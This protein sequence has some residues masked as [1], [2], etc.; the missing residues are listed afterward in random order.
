MGRFAKFS[1]TNLNYAANLSN[2][3]A[4][5]IFLYTVYSRG[6]TIIRLAYIST[7]DM[8]IFTVS[9]IGTDYQSMQIPVPI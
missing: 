6:V 5:K 2:L 3:P 1:S 8:L 9:I 4:I 7:T